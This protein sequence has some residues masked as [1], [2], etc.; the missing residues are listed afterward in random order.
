MSPAWKKHRMRCVNERCATKT[1]MLSD[2]RIAGQE[3]PVHDQAAK[4]ATRQVGGG[5]AGAPCSRWPTSWPATDT[6]S[7]DAVTTYG[8]A[9]LD[10]DRKR[11]NRT[12]A[13]GLDETA[14][15]KAN[16][17]GR[18]HYATTVPMW[19]TTRSSTSC[20][21]AITPRWPTGWTNSQGPGSSALPLVPS[22]CRGPT[23]RSIR[24]SC[25]KRPRWSTPSTSSPWPT[26]ASM[27]CDA[28]P[29]G[30]IRPPQQGQR[31]ALMGRLSGPQG[32]GH[33][34]GEARRRGHG[35]PVVTPRA[36][37][38]ERRGGHCLSGQRT[39][40]RLL[41]LPRSRRRQ[42]HLRRAPDPLPHRGHAARGAPAG[43]HYPGL[44]RQD[45]QLPPGPRVQWAHRRSQQPDQ[46]DQTNRIS[47]SATSRTTASE[48]CSTPA[49]RTGGCWARSSS[50]DGR[51]PASFR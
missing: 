20:P 42:V 25:P 12:S 19:R 17:A 28:G 4:W 15:V 6:R 11:L 27:R 43:P 10:A 1:W 50:D 37:R 22:T 30:A 49:N 35:A 40:T 24:S 5:R 32:P 33:G 7:N 21:P 45:H 36:R 41:S 31:P 3:L 47:C 13:I 16:A 23:R 51:D 29:R 39:A 46:A 26:A 48:R 9:L 14:F 2:H 38:S 34:R 8:E 18:T 44:V